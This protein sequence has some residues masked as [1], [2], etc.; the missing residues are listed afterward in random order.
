[1]EDW[2]EKDSVLDYG[3]SGVIIETSDPQGDGAVG[4]EPP[5]LTSRT[6][7][8]IEDVDLVYSRENNLQLQIHPDDVNVRI[9]QA[10]KKYPCLFHRKTSHYKD[11]VY[12]K[13]QWRDVSREV[14]STHLLDE[15]CRRIFK[16]L[17]RE[18]SVIY[19]IL[20]D[21][22]L[23]E[24]GWHRKKI[25]IYY[26]HMLFFRDQVN[27]PQVRQNDVNAF[28]KKTRKWEWWKEHKAKIDRQEAAKAKALQGGEEQEVA[29]PEA[30]SNDGIESLMEDMNLAY[31]V[32][33]NLHEKIP[34]DDFNLKLINAIK[35]YSSA[36]NVYPR[37]MKNSTVSIQ[38]NDKLW[39]TVAE[40]LG[41]TE[42][43]C[44]NVF[45]DL[46]NEFSV[47]Y[48]ILQDRE[49]VEMGLHHQRKIFIYYDHMLFFKDLIDVPLVRHHQ[50]QSI[51]KRAQRAQRKQHRAPENA[52][53]NHEDVDIEE[54]IAKTG[55]LDVAYVKEKLKHLQIHP[56]DPNVK[57]I[58]AVKEYPCLYDRNLRYKESRAWQE[59]TLKTNIKKSRKK[60]QALF[61]EFQA[62]FVIL[63]D[64]QL[65]A[66]GLPRPFIY[67]ERMLFMREKV[68]FNHVKKYV[69]PLIL[70]TQ[71]RKMKKMQ[72]NS[73][74]KENQS[75]SGG[76]FRS[77]LHSST[78]SELNCPTRTSEASTQEEGLQWGN[79][80]HPQEVTSFFYQL[81][82]KVTKSNIGYETFA[83]MKKEIE[84]V[85]EGR[86][87]KI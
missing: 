70:K 54:I 51:V 76:S 82:E 8:P 35:V 81:S 78:L 84:M 44:R 14:Y 39:A 19:V 12:T 16:A 25:F 40:S 61:R 57:L 17:F 42:R 80:L 15:D 34:P 13:N 7:T 67:Y 47:I 74:R 36:T 83:E 48:G 75:E 45:R 56:D 52:Q 68:D 22:K 62:T 29:A 33:N 63:R 38:E 18:F 21:R 5:E 6:R 43:K 3:F 20:R 26:D 31:V 87:A 23:M 77:S 60:F 32:D 66:E 64:P 65:T 24:E 1:M 11:P 71:K 55:D 73:W 58:E 30:E 79:V 86:M 46:L 49:L 69:V 37:M 28:L 85:V 9:I 50:V 41:A 2:Q 10:V 72:R 59:I 4:Q 27:I 53:I